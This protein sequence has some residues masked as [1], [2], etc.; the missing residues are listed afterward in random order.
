[1]DTGK[2]LC[3]CGIDTGIGKTVVTGL[4]ARALRDLDRHVITQKMVQTGCEHESE[5]ILAHR[6]TMG[7]DVLDEDRDGTTCPYIFPIPCSPHLA[8]RL[9][10]TEIEPEVIT[11]A[12]ASLAERYSL[13]LLEAAGGLFVPLSGKYLIIDY[14]KDQGYPVV[15]VSSS[16]LGSINH[17]LAMLEALQ[18]RGIELSGLI[19]N[20]YNEE[21]SQIGDD[22]KR[23]LRDFLNI[24]HFSCP[25]VE[26]WA[27]DAPETTRSL[28]HF[29]RT[30]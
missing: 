11:K 12:T 10:G 17:T 14:I 28:M 8:A 18:T 30:L 3:V 7:I 13:V 25:I 29:A 4:L 27:S 1:M 16:R 21:N 19:Y 15:L 6:Q 23:V 22:S 9:A 5:D 2:I 26:V 20:R 24:Y